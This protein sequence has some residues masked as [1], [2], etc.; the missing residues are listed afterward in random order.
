[1]FERM[2]NTVPRDVKLT[3]VI[4]PLKIKPRKLSVTVNDD[5]TLSVSGFIRVSA[6][7]PPAA[8][9]RDLE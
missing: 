4:K 6:T 8:E 3:D 9:P 2:I 5:Q 7:F 1:M